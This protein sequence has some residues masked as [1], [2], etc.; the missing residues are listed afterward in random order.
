MKHVRLFEDF[1]LNERVK[2]ELGNLDPK[3]MKDEPKIKQVNDILK[4]A[5]GKT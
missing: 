5:E 3:N 2:V 4:Q 1:L